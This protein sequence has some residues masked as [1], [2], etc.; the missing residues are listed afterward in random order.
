MPIATI[1]EHDIRY[2]K[3]VLP[4]LTHEDCR[5]IAPMPGKLA[6]YLVNKKKYLLVKKGTPHKKYKGEWQ[7]TFQPKERKFLGLHNSEV[8]KQVYLFLL[9]DDKICA[10]GG[11]DAVKL[12]DDHDSGRQIKVRVIQWVKND[13]YSVVSPRPIGEIR[14]PVPRC[15]IAKLKRF[16]FS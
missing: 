6:C 2:S 10:L 8:D 9:C 3:A 13:S 12:T 4:I 1:E 15:S 16:F 7:F 11:D 5:E 14:I